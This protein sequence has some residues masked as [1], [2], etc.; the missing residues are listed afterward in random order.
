VRRSLAERA[1]DGGNEVNTKKIAHGKAGGV[2][3]QYA[4]E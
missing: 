4:L 2:K 1:V 3:V